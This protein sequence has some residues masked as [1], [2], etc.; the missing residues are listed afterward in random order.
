MQILHSRQ[1]WELELRTAP[2]GNLEAR[3]R[4]GEVER[5]C[6]KREQQPGGVWTEEPGPL[7][8]LVPT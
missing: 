5:L 4:R 2:T 8:E 1:H 7:S 6:C 3:R